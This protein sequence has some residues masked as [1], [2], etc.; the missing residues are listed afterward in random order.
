MSREQ[1]QVDPARIYLIPGIVCHPTPAFCAPAIS[2]TVSI[3][4]ILVSV[5]QTARVPTMVFVTT[6]KEDPRRRPGIPARH[7][8]EPR[9]HRVGA[10]AAAGL[11]C[12]LCALS[13]K[14]VQP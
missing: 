14:G 6:T 1:E 10:P 4:L 9:R 5:A 13:S 8:R 12:A 7:L 2:D 3:S 11:P